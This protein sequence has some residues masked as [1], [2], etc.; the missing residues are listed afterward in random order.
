MHWS[1]RRALNT[2]G[3]QGHTRLDTELTDAIHRDMTSVDLHSDGF[4]HWLAGFIDGEGCF[5]VTRNAVRGHVTYRCDFQLHIR[6]DDGPILRD[7]CERTGLGRVYGPYDK[8]G[9]NAKPQLFWVVATKAGC[10]GLVR[11]LDE[12]PLRAKKARDYAI[13]RDAVSEWCSNGHC[14]D[15]E[16]MSALRDQLM[17][18]RAHVDEQVAPTIVAPADPQLR[19]VQQLA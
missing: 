3:L 5:S 11:L 17:V 15:W 6:E 13:W 4:G 2:I 8:A 10:A 7:I 18:I 16:A 14:G 19:L 9:V 12:F 1:T